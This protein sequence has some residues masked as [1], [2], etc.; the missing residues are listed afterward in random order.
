MGVIEEAASALACVQKVQLK[1]SRMIDESDLDPY[2]LCWLHPP[3][4]LCTEARKVRCGIVT[5]FRDA[6]CLSSWVRFHM[7]VGFSSI[8]L[9]VDDPSTT[10]M[11]EALRLQELYPDTVTAIPRDE[12]LYATWHQL[13]GWKKYGDTVD[14][15][16]DHGA[17]MARQCMNGEY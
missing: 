11:A 1:R 16:G 13:T 6:P 7:A 10:D 5:T 14:K 12:H 15:V 17:V 4:S 8:W 9:F 3:R 2:D